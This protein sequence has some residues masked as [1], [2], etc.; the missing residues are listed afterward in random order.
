[1][2]HLLRNAVLLTSA[3]TALWSCQRWEAQPEPP[4]P[5]LASL[6]V[7]LEAVQ[8]QLALFPEFGMDVPVMG[9][10]G[11]ANSESE[12]AVGFDGTNYLVVWA[13]GR[14]GDD[15]DLYGVRVSPS[16]TVI[17][18]TAIAISTAPDSQLSP[19]I[20]FNG[21]VYLVVWLVE[22]PFVWDVGATRIDT[23]GNVLDPGGI[24]ITPAGYTTDAPDVASDGSGFLVVWSEDLNGPMHIHAATVDGLGD[25]G[26]RFT[27]SASS[28]IQ[29]KPSI[30]FD[31][32]NYVIAWTS[33]DS[34]RAAR[35]NPSETVLD[36]ASI[37][38]RS[39]VT[40]SSL[41]PP[42]VASSGGESLIV[43]SEGLSSSS[44]D[45]YGA[46][47]SRS[48]ARLDPV[49]FPIVSMKGLS[50]LEFDGTN[51]LALWTDVSNGSD[52]YSTRVAP[53][54]AVL[55]PTGV[56]LAA[57][58][59]LEETGPALIAGDGGQSLLVY[60]RFDSDPAVQT[61]RVRGRIVYLDE[62]PTGTTCGADGECSSGHCVDGVCCE[63]S[64]GG[65]DPADCQACSQSA[66]ASSNGTCELLPT[67]YVCRAASGTCDIQE[68]C[69][70]ASPVCPSDV[71]E[72][73]CGP[74]ASD[75]G[76]AGEDGGSGAEDGGT[77]M[78]GAEFVTQ[79]ETRALCGTPYRYGAGPPQ[80]DAAPP[81]VF[82][83]SEAPE[84]LSVDPHTGE[85][86]W[87]PTPD[88]TGV[89]RVALSATGNSGAS[90]QS[91]E[92]DVECPRK[93]MAVGYGCRQS[94]G[95]PTWLPGLFLIALWRMRRAVAP[96]R[97]D[98]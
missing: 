34:I 5:S 17:D 45:V 66:G 44:S 89:H 28:P 88:Q 68:S 48:G 65:G 37:V 24:R 1:M 47:L 22:R 25:V 46:R 82:S 20:A 35:V 16:G 43:W 61:T 40:P 21:S 56:A 8:R 29:S 76:V 59:I 54:G 58:P 23:A 69:S 30:A 6:P 86:H 74:D 63:S 19:K 27:V 11:G 51:Y 33:E 83:L 26:V 36:P 71:S 55:D 77:G 98:E 73:P 50:G 53:A 41:W 3:L 97:S 81:V 78:P 39:G 12:P 84:G 94:A 7:D 49:A 9:P 70:G 2:N 13:D 42:R 93:A 75:G 72:F 79:P 4:T 67:N 32:L 62:S 64:C 57:D 91:F 38:L 10:P 18:S 90:V 31:G 60:Q 52:V 95:T 87:T 15:T 92:V 14:N 80:V 85:L 96:V